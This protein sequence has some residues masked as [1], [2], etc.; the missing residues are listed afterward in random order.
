MRRV[1]EGERSA[2]E[3]VYALHHARAHRLAYGVLL[4]REEAREAVQE[5]FLR[6]HRDAG[7][8]EPRAA[9]ATWI[10]RVVLN[11]CLSLRR[12]LVRLVFAEP[13]TATSRT[14]EHET[15]LAETERAVN[16][17]LRELSPRD[18][19]VLTLHLDEDKKPAEIAELCGTTP[20]AT[21]VTLH[22]A[23]GRLRAELEA[24][25][26]E[27]VERTPLFVVSGEEA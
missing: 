2:F 1:A 27:I 26:V 15:S 13:L 10:H 9:I 19:A 17:V 23:L 4:D 8:W 16:A 7:R 3:R 12:R 5:V 20:G 18:R 6:L 24:R 11:H 21:R 14:P 25:G 22:R